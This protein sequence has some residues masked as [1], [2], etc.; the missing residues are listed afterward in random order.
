[1]HLI[2]YFNS[3]PHY[4]WFCSDPTAPRSSFWEVLGW[5][6]PSPWHVTRILGWAR[7]AGQRMRILALAQ[8]RGIRWVPAHARVVRHVAIAHVQLACFLRMPSCLAEAITLRRCQ[9]YVPLTLFNSLKL[10]STYIFSAN[11]LG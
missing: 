1:M 7:A 10:H 2:T 3:A 5:T 8:P 4:C 9:L 11:V 6:C